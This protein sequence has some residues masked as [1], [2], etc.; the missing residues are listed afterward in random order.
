[1]SIVN[2]KIILK[3]FYFFQWRWINQMIFL[4]HIRS[5]F[6]RT[7]N[8][9]FVVIEEL[10]GLEATHS[11]SRGSDLFETPKNLGEKNNMEWRKLVSICTEGP[12]AMVGS[13]S[14][15]LT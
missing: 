6:F 10:L 9:N 13:K 12:P 3:K 2:Y 1:M 11:S 8:D 5:Q 15:C 7:I 14:G 4:I